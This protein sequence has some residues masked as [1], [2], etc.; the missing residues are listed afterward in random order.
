MLSVANSKRSAWD[1]DAAESAQPLLLLL[2][3][4]LPL[5]LL[6]LLQW[7]T[8]EIRCEDEAVCITDVKFT[9]DGSTSGVFSR[10]SGVGT[11]K[12]CW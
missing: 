6:L 11:K 9:K 3:P 7:N 12:E 10:K 8:W 2:P 5:L 1:A 4:L